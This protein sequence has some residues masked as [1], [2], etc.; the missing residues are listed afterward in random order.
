MCGFARR[1]CSRGGMGIADGIADGIAGSQCRRRHPTCRAIACSQSRRRRRNQS[2][3]RRSRRLNHRRNR[4]RQSR[5]QNRRWNRQ[6]GQL[7]RRLNHSIRRTSQ[8]LTQHHGGRCRSHSRSPSPS[9]A[10]HPI[11]GPIHSPLTRSLNNSS[12]SL[13]REI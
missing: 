10:I 7:I 11:R 2:R 4:R 5:R 1:T 3:R 12:S 8:S 9:I 6:Q 13:K